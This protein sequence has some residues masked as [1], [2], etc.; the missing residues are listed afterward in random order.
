MA[1]FKRHIGFGF[2][3]GIAFGIAAASYAYIDS[4]SIVPVVFMLSMLGAL[5]PDL[6]SDSSLPFRFVLW[7][8]TIAMVGVSFV[9]VADMGTDDLVFIIGIPLGTYIIARYVIG[10]TMKKF[11]IHRG[12]MH[13]IP[14]A[15]IAG[16]LTY[17]AT[18]H[19]LDAQAEKII[20]A[21]AVTV[22][23]LSHLVLDE[24]YAF[25]NFNGK[26]FR[27]KRSLGSALKW[28]SNSAKITLLTYLALGAILVMIV[29]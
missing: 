2:I 3:V 26:P 12:M 5:L 10:R 17:A 6:D 15:A 29:L 4:L 7:F 8:F 16:L 1:S 25:T 23:Y 27:P 21:G 14:A 11:T 22:G 24:I 19:L 9:Y 20:I 13:S 18:E 28:K